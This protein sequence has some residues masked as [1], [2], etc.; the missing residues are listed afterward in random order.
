I[1]AVTPGAPGDV[2]QVAADLE[3]AARVRLL[4]ATGEVASLAQPP[5][6]RPGD[7]AVVEVDP[8]AT[9]P[10][11]DL[12]EGGERLRQEEGV[13][14]G[15]GPAAP[16][17]LVL[18]RPQPVDDQTEHVPHRTLLGGGRSSYSRTS[19]DATRNCDQQPAR[20]RLDW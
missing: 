17:P 5:P 19:P 9:L 15:R 13:R 10:L 7:V 8:G 14:H 6:E 3:P 12:A 18:A 11:A 2:R 16:L 4:Q 20:L 1:A